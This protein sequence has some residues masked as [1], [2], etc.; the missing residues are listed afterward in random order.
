MMYNIPIKPSHQND[1]MIEKNSIN[2]IVG[3]SDIELVGSFFKMKHVRNLLVSKKNML[4]SDIRT[5]KDIEIEIC[6]IQKEVIERMIF[7]E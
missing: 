4:E 3:M 1:A 7:D 6:Y 5:I 2:D